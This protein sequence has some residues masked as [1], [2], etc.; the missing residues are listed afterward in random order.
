ML[1]VIYAEAFASALTGAVRFLLACELSLPGVSAASLPKA[2]V[3]PGTVSVLHRLSTRLKPSPRQLV[4]ATAGRRWRGMVMG[5]SHQPVPQRELAVS[6]GWMSAAV[7]AGIEHG[8]ASTRCPRSTAI[9]AAHA[10]T[11][12]VTRR[13]AAR[14]RRVADAV[15][16]RDLWLVAVMWWWAEEVARPCV[17]GYPI[18]I[19]IRP[20]ERSNRPVPGGCHEN[21][22]TWRQ[23]HSINKWWWT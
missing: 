17:S 9:V 21:A 15:L 11:H 20:S 18:W 19:C 10:R 16:V 23:S 2:L 3:V 12:Y 5:W 13:P 22:G 7:S 14:A 8:N 4:S 1:P 6:G